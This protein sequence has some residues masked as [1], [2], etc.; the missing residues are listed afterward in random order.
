MQEITFNLEIGHYTRYILFF[1]FS[2]ILHKLCF[3]KKGNR[4]RQ[5]GSI[6]SVRGV[7][8]HLKA[9]KVKFLKIKRHFLGEEDLATMVN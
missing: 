8:F 3:F 7:L 4:Q 1:N 6:T 9:K 5:G 2:D